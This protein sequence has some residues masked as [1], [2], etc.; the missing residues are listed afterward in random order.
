MGRYP[1]ET[2][3]MI[4]IGQKPILL[5]NFYDN[6]N[7]VFPFKT[8]LKYHHL[9][10]AL[11]WPR[12]GYVPLSSGLPQSLLSFHHGVG[13]YPKSLHTSQFLA[14]ISLVL[15]CHLRNPFPLSIQGSS[16]LSYMALFSPFHSGLYAFF[17]LRV[18]VKTS[19][20]SLCSVQ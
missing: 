7:L 20:I 13:H 10:E 11:H 5:P 3:L 17:T 2:K 9:L 12:L 8:Q 16:R 19:P 1:R 18:L 4:G 15:L 6:W 14:V